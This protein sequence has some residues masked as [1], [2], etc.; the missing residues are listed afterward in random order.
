LNGTWLLVWDKEL[1]P[2]SLIVILLLT[3]S[4]GAAYFR[5]QT[6]AYP[7]HLISLRRN[8]G[9]PSSSTEE[10]T[11]IIPAAVN[12]NT[13][14]LTSASHLYTLKKIGSY[15]VTRLPF[16]LYFGWL[17]A[18]SLVNTFVVF[19]PIDPKAPT[20]TV[21]I[22]L[23]SLT[24]LSLFCLYL[25]VHWNE[26]VVSLVA[27]WAL[28]GISFGGAVETYPGEKGGEIVALWTWSLAVALGVLI[29]L[30][31]V[32][33]RSILLFILTRIRRNDISHSD[34]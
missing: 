23:V 3:S 27:I 16:A 21:P 34:V 11:P 17:L 6:L 32:F 7:K 1:L 28:R 20:A 13:E 14:P 15:I 22:A 5:S 4:V 8:N 29:V 18:A 12:S 25:L 24:L 10:T 9:S 33:G 30:W 2:V 31:K 26:P 19:F